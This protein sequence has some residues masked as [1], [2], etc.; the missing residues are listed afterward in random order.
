VYDL[1]QTKSA[2]HGIKEYFLK[3]FI[4]LFERESEQGEGR[5]TNR[6]LAEQGARCRAP[7]QDPEIMI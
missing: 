6:L 2:P 5:G 4:Y 3:D 7:S 1:L